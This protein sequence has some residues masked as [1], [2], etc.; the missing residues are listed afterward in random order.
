MMDRRA[1]LHFLTLCLAATGVA[2]GNDQTNNGGTGGHAGQ[3]GASGSMSGAGSATGGAGG[4]ATA[5]SGGTTESG[6]AA[7]DMG[8]SG[9]QAH[10]GSAGM[11][12][13]GHAGSG[14]A[15]RGGSGGTGGTGGTGGKPGHAGAGSNSGGSGNEAGQAP[16][17]AWVNATGNLANMA[18]ECGNLTMI[19]AVPDSTTVIA[20]VAH[21]G[22]F[23]TSDSG[24]H[25]NALGTGAGSAVIINRPSSIVYEPNDPNTF[26]ETGIYNGGGLYKTTDAGQTFVQLGDISHNDLVSVDFTDPNRQTLLVGG[27]EQKQTLYLSR[28][29]GQTFTQIGMNLPADSHF[30]SAPLVLDS[31]TFLLGA[32]GYGDGTCGVFRSTDGGDTWNQVSDQPA[33]A[34][35]LVA[36]D[37]SIYW[38]L[39]NGNGIARGTPDGTTWVKTADNIIAAYPVE[40][41][42]GRIMTI[43]G[44]HVVV[45]PDQGVTWNP[46]G[47]TIPFSSPAGVTYS[48]RT[49]TMFVYHWDCGSIV[50]PD[51]IASA[52]FDYTLE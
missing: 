38:S 17:S 27:H 3:S 51:A 32:C 46:V 35:P 20:G 25:W 16:D 24:A 13:N 4:T 29:G 23:A 37:G 49:K 19:S 22:V 9:G 47:D 26:W 28:D 14:A 44:D 43:R 42:D 5:G 11:H 52:G 15:G 33:V 45:S 12:G 8:G 18:S 6:G 1:R 50:L 36:S 34:R 41:P 39:V 21:V 2:C 48:V 30:S 7:G 10:A 40:L 31:Q